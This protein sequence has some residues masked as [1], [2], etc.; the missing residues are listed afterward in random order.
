MARELY[1]P[2]GVMPCVVVSSVTQPKR[3]KTAMGKNLRRVLRSTDLLAWKQQAFASLVRVVWS[4]PHKPL[5]SFD[6]EARKI[7]LEYLPPASE[8]LHEAPM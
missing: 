1:D 5:T 7:N 8:C 2:L 6:K 4:S 3:E